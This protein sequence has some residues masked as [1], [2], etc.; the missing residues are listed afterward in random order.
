LIKIKLRA[1]FSTFFDEVLEEIGNNQDDRVLRRQNEAGNRVV[2]LHF[3]GVK[4][5]SSWLLNTSSKT[6]SKKVLNPALS[7][8]LIKFFV[9]ILL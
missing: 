5:R 4:P 6:S 1:G 8:I 3:D 7:F 2:W 9:R